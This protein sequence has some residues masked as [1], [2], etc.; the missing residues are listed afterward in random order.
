MLKRS[1]ILTG[2]LI[3]STINLASTSVQAADSQLTTQ[4]TEVSVETSAEMQD[5]SE[6]VKRS[7]L[8]NINSASQRELTSLAGIGKLKAERIVA[9]REQH[10]GFKSIDEL[11]KVSGIGKKTVA[12]ISNYITIQ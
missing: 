10:G 9:W 7:E 4:P 8:I 2:Y 5:L 6:L 11:V 12:N 3:V 1:L